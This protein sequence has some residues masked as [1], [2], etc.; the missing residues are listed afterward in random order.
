MIIVQDAFRGKNV[1]ETTNSFLRSPVYK[2]VNG[3]LSVSE[4]TFER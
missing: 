3:A 1:L 4:L 2:P